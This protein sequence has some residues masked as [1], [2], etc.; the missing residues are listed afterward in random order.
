MCYKGLELP[1]GY[2]YILRIDTLAFRQGIE[3]RDSSETN[4]A[5]T[6]IPTHIT[7]SNKFI[8]IDYFSQ[9]IKSIVIDHFYYGFRLLYFLTRTDT[10][11]FH[12]KHCSSDKRNWNFTVEV[13]N[14]RCKSNTTCFESQPNRRGAV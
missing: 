4:K 10:F 7:I 11:F 9:K 3:L 6:T 8:R 13:L 12:T 1:Q 5:N 14:K 2:I